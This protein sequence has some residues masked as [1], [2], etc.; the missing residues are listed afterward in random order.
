MRLGKFRLSLQKK[1]FCIN[2]KET[3]EEASTNPITIPPLQ[4]SAKGLRHPRDSPRKVA[5][6][7]L[8][9][10]LEEVL[11]MA[12]RRDAQT[13]HPVM[14]RKQPV[15]SEKECLACP[16][17]LKERKILTRGIINLPSF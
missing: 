5:G 7:V 15:L 2:P 14:G 8:C 12:S 13:M 10:P 11:T 1:C 4:A 6:V 3:P 16:R 9:C 17:L